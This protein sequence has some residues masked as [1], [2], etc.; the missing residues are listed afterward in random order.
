MHHIKHIRH[1]AFVLIPPENTW[2]QIM[3]LRNRKQIPVCQSCHMKKI[4]A[5]VYNGPL[6]KSLYKAPPLKNSLVDARVVHPESFIQPGEGEKYVKKTL[7]EK[8][9]FDMHEIHPI[10]QK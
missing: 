6:L 5:G 10:F 8:G 2:E 1:K 3:S 9:W 7:R 4:H